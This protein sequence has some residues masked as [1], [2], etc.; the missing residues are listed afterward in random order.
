MEQSSVIMTGLDKER[1][2]QGIES[3][4]NQQITNKRNILEV[5]DYKIPNVSLK[6]ER[7]ILS[8]IS[9]VNRVIWQ[10]ES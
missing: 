5:A 7:I 9:Y 3:V 2:L 10:K 1:I 8:Y 4:K 6:M